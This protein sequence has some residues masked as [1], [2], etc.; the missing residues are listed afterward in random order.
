M[1]TLLTLLALLWHLPGI[2]ADDIEQEENDRD[3]TRE[4]LI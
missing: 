1:K 4:R 3:E 2:I